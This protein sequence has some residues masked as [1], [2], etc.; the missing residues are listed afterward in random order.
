MSSRLP[1]HPATL[2]LEWLCL[3]HH[4][5]HGRLN[6]G[7]SLQP[8]SMLDTSET[9]TPIW[10]ESLKWNHNKMENRLLPCPGSPCLWTVLPFRPGDDPHV[11]ISGDE[12][13]QGVV[14]TYVDDLLLTDG[15]II[16]ML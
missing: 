5:W 13:T 9:E 12:L 7:M 14:L 8:F 1:K 10:E 4:T 16:S 3:L 2:P 15:N 6:A 11:K